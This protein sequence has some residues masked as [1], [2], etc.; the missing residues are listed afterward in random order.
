[1]SL[2]SFLRERRRLF[3]LFFT[4]V[5]AGK[6]ARRLENLGKRK[7]GLSGRLIETG[8]C[9][10]Y[11]VAMGQPGTPAV[12][13]EADSGGWSADWAAAQGEAAAIARTIS[14]DRA[15][16]GWSESARRPRTLFHMAEE[17]H[18]LLYN[19]NIQ[20]PYVLVGRG[21][22][23]L[24]AEYF[25]RFYPDETAG[26]VL[27]GEMTL[28]EI[29]RAAQSDLPTP[30][31]DKL[32]TK[33]MRSKAYR[34]VLKDQNKRIIEAGAEGLQKQLESAGPLTEVPIIRLRGDAPD[35]EVVE[36]I[37]STFFSA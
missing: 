32:A 1:M 20:H 31:G 36:A 6:L 30:A 16:H 5:G 17:L 33:Q 14:Y 28:E 4:Q 24:L 37:R 8:G 27:I 26:L 29:V 10:L 23:A 9:K 18:A 19:A 12:V 34:S 22:G 13:F 7:K 21:F 25:A 15:G 3:L 35:Q 2:S 11:I